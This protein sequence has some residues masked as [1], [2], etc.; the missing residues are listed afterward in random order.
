MGLLYMVVN[1]ETMEV[2]QLGALDTICTKQFLENP[3]AVIDTAPVGFGGSYSC[4]SKEQLKTMATHLGLET[5]M[6]YGETIQA[7]KAA[8]TAKYAEIKPT[9]KTLEYY[10]SQLKKR[11]QKEPE[12]YAQFEPVSPDPVVSKRFSASSENKANAPKSTTPATRP[13]GGTT[14]KVWDIADALRE[15]NPSLSAKELRPKIIEACEQEGINSSTAGTQYS[16]WK[17]TV[18]LE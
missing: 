1:R 2:L 3:E 10:E 13:A 16:K 4:Y 11:M 15:R 8:L 5:T 7:I 12:L 18:G 6:A 17:N 9:L 14:K